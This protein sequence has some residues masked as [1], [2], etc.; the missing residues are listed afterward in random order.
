V[1]N[2]AILGRLGQ[3]G[4]TIGQQIVITSKFALG[5]SASWEIQFAKL[6]GCPMEGEKGCAR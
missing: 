3:L 5:L 4:F 2:L 6:G 1:A